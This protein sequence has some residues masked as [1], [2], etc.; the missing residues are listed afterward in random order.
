MT[1]QSGIGRGFYSEEEMHEFNLEINKLI[2]KKTSHRGIDHFFFCPHTPFD[3]CNCR[4]PKNDLV[5]QALKFFKCSPTEALLIGDKFSD[6]QAGLRTGVKSI[7][8]DRENNLNC[9]KYLAND[10]VI[11]KSLDIKKIGDYLI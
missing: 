3:K 7:L 11:L 8:L 9:D 5:K 2:R 6:C 1:N 4:K 10:I